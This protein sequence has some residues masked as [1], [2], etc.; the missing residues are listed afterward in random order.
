MSLHE[1]ADLNPSGRYKHDSRYLLMLLCDHQ[2]FTYLLVRVFVSL[3]SLHDG[4]LC[5]VLES[6]RLVPQN[7]L[8]HPQSQRSDSVLGEET[9]RL[10]SQEPE[11][12]FIN[13]YLEREEEPHTSLSPS[14][15]SRSRRMVL[16][17]SSHTAR[18]SSRMI[19]SSST[20][21]PLR[22]SER[23]LWLDS[24]FRRSATRSE[25]SWPSACQE[26]TRGG[27]SQIG[28]FGPSP[29]HRPSVISLGLNFKLL[30]GI[31][32]VWTRE[33]VK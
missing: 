4:Q 26:R 3:Q 13:T 5:V 21:A 8:Q 10:S 23:S 28:R 31:F 30:W 27:T 2:M 16:K 25:W 19:F 17:C 9:S 7:L 20:R 12:R 11:I 15:S 18:L 6:G 14:V 1:N 24:S 32:P 22:S 29:Q 33:T